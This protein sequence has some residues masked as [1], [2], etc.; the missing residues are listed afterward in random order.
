MIIGREGLDTHEMDCDSNLPVGRTVVCAAPRPPAAELL[1][2]ACFLRGGV[3]ADQD[4]GDG[5][6]RRRWG[7]HEISAPA[8]DGK[9]HA[10]EIATARDGLVLRSCS[11]PALGSNPLPGTY[12]SSPRLPLLP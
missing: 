12:L 11:H 5:G 10:S 1:S 8:S 9:P 7:A 4:R 6:W 3:T 2:L